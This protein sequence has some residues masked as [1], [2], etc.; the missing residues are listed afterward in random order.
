VGKLHEITEEEG[1]TAQMGDLLLMVAEACMAAKDFE[2]AKEIGEEALKVSRR[3]AGFDNDRTN[4]VVRLLEAV[5]EWEK[6]SA[7]ASASAS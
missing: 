1:L 4:D 5:E 6:E 3:Y 7:S 2:L